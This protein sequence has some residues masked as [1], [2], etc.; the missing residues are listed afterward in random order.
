MP[1][2]L[3]AS[4]SDAFTTPLAIELNLSA[5][6]PSPTLDARLVRPGKR[7]GWV[8]GDL[9]W[10]KV[11]MLRH[12]G[13]P[14]AHV[15]LLQEF[16]A[17]YRNSASNSTGYYSYSY[18]DAKTISL[19]KFESSQ[20][21]PLLDEARRIGVRLVQAR[22]Q[23]DVPAYATAQLCLDVTADESGDLVVTP[24]LQVDGATARPVAFIGSSGHGVV[25]P[26]R[27]LRLARLD[28][29]ASKAL[30]RWRSAMN[31]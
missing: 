5:S 7:G 3:T 27:G 12:Y 30:Q 15:Q 1:C 23:H 31:P 13:Y 24:V 19:L 11:A 8:A 26:D 14:N 22:A 29:P 21:W 25:Y 2:S 28:K 20:L 10:S 18:A 6:G 16:Y 4:P 17:A 9:S